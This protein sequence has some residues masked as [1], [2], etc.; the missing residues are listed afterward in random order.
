RDLFMMTLE[1][2]DGRRKSV[3]WTRMVLFDAERIPAISSDAS[4]ALRSRLVAFLRS[5]GSRPEVVV[6]FRHL[7]EG[8]VDTPEPRR[9]RRRGPA[10][11]RRSQGRSAAACRCLRFSG[12]RG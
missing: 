2:P 7:E 3:G 8:W 12:G 6:T 4:H 9:E 1:S 11:R 5:R 10:G